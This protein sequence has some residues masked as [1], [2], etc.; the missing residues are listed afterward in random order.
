MRTASNKCYAAAVVAAAMMQSP[1]TGVVCA[2]IKKLISILDHSKFCH[3]YGS[4]LKKKKKLG[5]E[6]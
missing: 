3:K 6:S 4:I 5:R 1:G 2:Q